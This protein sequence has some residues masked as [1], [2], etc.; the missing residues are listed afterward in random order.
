MNFVFLV[1]KYERWNINK[2]TSF[3]F[4]LGA[5]RRGHTVYVLNE[6]GMTRKNGRILMCVNRVNPQM[7]PASPFGDIQKVILTEDQIDAVFI[8]TDPPFDETYLM[9]TWMLDLLPKHVP[10]LNEP[11]GLR[12]C[13]EKIWATQFSE[14]IPPT[15]V[16][17]QQSEILQFIDENKLVV[18]KPVNGFGGQGIVRLSNTNYVEESLI[19]LTRRWSQE[20]IVQ[21]YIPEAEV[22]DKRILLL[23]GEPLGAVLRVH[24]ATDFRN[25]FMS[26]GTAQPTE[27]TLHELDMCE[28]L[29]PHLQE[30]GLYFVGID[31]IGPYLTEINV[32]SPTCVQEINKLNNVQLEDQV[33]E[34]T[35]KLIDQ[36]RTPS[37][38]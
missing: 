21:K 5:S 27:I 36:L 11:S 2:D 4:M 1:D 28:K 26:G 17:Q 23:N 20:I 33:M 38:I 30:K 32:T 13:N 14:L 7:N 10:V 9:Q 3:C 6:G 18:A 16:S 34:F 19:K 12:D 31:V 35:E 15:L 8:R 37:T 22:G 25:N 24:S 29:K